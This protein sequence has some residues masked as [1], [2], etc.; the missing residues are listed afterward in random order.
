[1]NEDD[2]D[3]TRVPRLPRISK[4]VQFRGAEIIGHGVHSEVYTVM[5]TYKKRTV[6]VVIKTLP[7]QMERAL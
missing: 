2:I 7:C 1:M 6:K 3:P 4:A 5:A